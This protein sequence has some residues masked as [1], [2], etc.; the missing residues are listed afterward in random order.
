MWGLE[1][2]PAQI[3][4]E[5]TWSLCLKNSPQYPNHG[6]E[7]PQLLNSH[8]ANFKTRNVRVKSTLIAT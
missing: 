2:P 5:G 3:E 7:T 6:K 8:Q 1:L 4:R